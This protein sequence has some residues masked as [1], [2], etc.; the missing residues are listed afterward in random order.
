MILQPYPEYNDSGHPCI[1][2]IPSHWQP[3]RNGRLFSQR[4]ETGFGE[5]PILEVSLRT[6]V[7]V[8][9]MDSL[10]RKQMMSD[11]E[12]YK[13]AAQGDL[14]YNMMRMWQGAVGLVPIDGLVS[15]A[16]IVLRP[17]PGT[18]CRYFSYLFRTDYY[19]SEI[20]AHSRGIVKDRNRLYWQDFKQMISIVPP[21][22]EQRK[23]CK[24]LC[25]LDNVINRFIRNKRKLIE[26][27]KEQ[28]QAIINQAVTR[29]LDPNV[30]LKPS[31]VPCLGD[32][33]EHWESTRLRSVAKINPS[34]VDKIISENEIPTALCNYTDVYK[35]DY[36]T[37]LLEFMQGSATLD[38]INKFK[39]RQGDVLITKDSESWKDIGVPAYVNENFQNVVC[40]YHLALMRPKTEILSGL[41]L[42]FLLKSSIVLDQ[43]RVAANGV[44]RFGLTQGAIKDVQICIPPLSEQNKISS[45]LQEITQDADQLL[46]KAEQQIQLIQEYRTRLI[47]DIVTGKID[48]RNIPIDNS[49]LEEDFESNLEKNDLA[50][51]EAE[52]KEKAY[53]DD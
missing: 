26:L 15:P 40:G 39:L 19:M 34:N 7:R 6:G 37:S 42:F 10:K 25:A 46:I 20:D 41:F 47:A 22:E 9:D 35:N 31:G 43:F 48:V 11:R 24:F 13:R 30:K 4:S 36:I 18:E 17:L 33:P 21:L 27:L 44:T 52:I 29:S 49:S 50:A 8:R 28:K 5:L 14:A 23:I 2:M 53:A 16:Y 51:P 3:L 38:E 32:I 1:S 45:Y 12:K